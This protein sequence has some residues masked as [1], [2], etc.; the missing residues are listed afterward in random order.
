MQGV[1]A[2]FRIA[3][4]F[5]VDSNDHQVRYLLD[6]E[7]LI[8]RLWGD[9]LGLDPDDV[10]EEPCPLTPGVASAPVSVARCNCGELGCGSESVLI[11]QTAGVVT[12]LYSGRPVL[13]VGLDSYEREL[14]R[15]VNDFTWET[16]DRVVRC[17]HPHGHPPTDISRWCQTPAGHGA[18]R[19]TTACR[20][21]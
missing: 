9:M 12:W 1:T 11:Q 10:L 3:V 14:T 15:A 17:P 20:P 18:A 6:G 16:P 7:D 4:S 13:A 5:S 21:Q 8:A 19:P 2:D